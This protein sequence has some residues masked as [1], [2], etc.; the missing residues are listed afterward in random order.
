MAPL[1]T[2]YQRYHWI[3]PWQMHIGKRNGV[4]P[5]LVYGG[6]VGGRFC[7][8]FNSMIQGNLARKTP[9]ADDQSHTDVLSEGLT[10]FDLDV[11]EARFKRLFCT[12]IEPLFDTFRP[13]T[14]RGSIAA[15]GYRL[16]SKI[17]RSP[18]H[19]GRPHHTSPTIKV[20]APVR[21]PAATT[22][23]NL[24]LR[25]RAHLSERRRMAALCRGQS[26]RQPSQP[27]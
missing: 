21:P 11:G 9:G 17:K 13:L 10:Q 25:R 24:K 18:A 20:I 3:L 2:P 22:T 26:S 7:G 5:F 6:V 27:A 14:A 19:L 15:L 8:I 12:E 4:T 1:T 16:K 23:V